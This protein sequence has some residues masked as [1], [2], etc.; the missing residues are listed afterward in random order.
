MDPHRPCRHH[1]VSPP[2]TSRI[3]IHAHRQRACSPRLSWN[4]DCRISGRVHVHRRFVKRD[5]SEHHY[6]QASRVAT[7]ILVAIASY[8]AAQLASIRS[9]WEFVLELGAGTGGV[10]LLRWFWWRINAWSEIA[11]MATALFVSLA[12]R[13][14]LPFSGASSVVFAKTALTTTV[15]TTL[16][17]V[18]VTLLT[19]PE[20]PE[21]LLR[22]YRKV[23]PHVSGWQPIARLAP[24]VPPTHDLGRNLLAWILGCAMVYMA[25]FGVG[26]FLVHQALLGVALLV[27]SA[28][29]GVLLYWDLARR[30]WGIVTDQES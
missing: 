26:K 14:H 17:W 8:I 11:A 6:V 7:L 27:G 1:S 28:I 13:W 29:C 10:Y 9:G 25:L 19:P 18:T 12:L 4:C 22:F 21:L 16:V 5:G 30:G 20:S 23:R 15:L 2:R 3:R 24:E